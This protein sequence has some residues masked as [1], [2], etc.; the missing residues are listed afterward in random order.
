M[1]D[2]R[3]Q[4]RRRAGVARAF[5]EQALEL[6]ELVAE[7]LDDYEPDWPHRDPESIALAL[8]I[9]NREREDRDTL[10]M[11]KFLAS[12][13]WAKLVEMETL[14]L[15]VHAYERLSQQVSRAAE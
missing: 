6:S 1:D 3:V 15:V 9:H 4:E 10:T 13:A 2:E 12:E 7:G 14:F 11:D 5:L 8:L